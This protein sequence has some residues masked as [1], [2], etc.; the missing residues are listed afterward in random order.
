[1]RFTYFSCKDT[2]FIDTLFK[3]QPTESNS[4]RTAKFT[5]I[6]TSLGGT[7]PLTTAIL[8]NIMIM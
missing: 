2:L 8:N 6:H 7:P 1:M 4:L 3:F 5:K